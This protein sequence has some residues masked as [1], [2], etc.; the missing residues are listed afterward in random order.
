MAHGL[1][2]H[3]VAGI[4]QNNRQIGGRSARHHVARILYVSRRVGDDELAARRGEVAVC[5]VD[6]Y[7]LFAFC[8]QTV[9]QQG[10][11]Q[12][13]VASVARGRFDRFQLIFKNRL[14]VV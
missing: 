10:E 8:T 2:Q 1:F 4:D 9:C 6:S 14:A 5:N 3:A 12:F 13:F 7:A 11:V